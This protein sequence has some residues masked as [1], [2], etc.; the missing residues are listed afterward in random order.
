[1]GCPF[2]ISSGFIKE[3]FIEKKKEILRGPIFFLTNQYASN[4]ANIPVPKQKPTRLKILE[5]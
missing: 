1:M 2:L 4:Q 3:S 5:L